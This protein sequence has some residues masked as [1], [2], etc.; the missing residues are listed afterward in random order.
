MR[1]FDIR[2]PRVQYTRYK[3]PTS[4]VCVCSRHTGYIIF[5]KKKKKRETKRR[6]APTVVNQIVNDAT[7]DAAIGI[8]DKHTQ[9]IYFCCLPTAA[10]H[11]VICTHTMVVTV[12]SVSAQGRDHLSPY[13]AACSNSTS[14]ILYIDFKYW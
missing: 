1:A 5:L 12:R 9:N 8:D 14:S 11:S 7:E 4:C 3:Q 2:T 13:A 6:T 10:V